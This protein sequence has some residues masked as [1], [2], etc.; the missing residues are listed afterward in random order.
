MFK[1][2]RSSL[3]RLYSHSFS[4]TLCT[5]NPFYLVQSGYLLLIVAYKKG[6]LDFVQVKQITRQCELFVGQC[7][8]LF[9]PPCLSANIIIVANTLFL[10]FLL[11]RKQ[12][13][14]LS[15]I[16]FYVSGKLKKKSNKSIKVVKYLLF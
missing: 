12:L 16:F 5:L 11:D 6:W 10:L 7:D 3:K 8:S 15:V 13:I 9:T 1:P 2:T 4:P 14:N